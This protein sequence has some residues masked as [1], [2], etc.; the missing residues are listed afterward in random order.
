MKKLPENIVILHNIRSVSN[1]GAMFR[2]ADAVGVNKIYLTGY[3]PG[4]LDRFGRKRKD[5]AK[6]ALGA[7]E[8]V[9]WEQKK[10]LPA[11]ISRLKKEGYLVVAI[12]QDSRSV[13]YRKLKLKN[14]NAFI[15]GPEVTGIPK[16]ILNK[17]DIIA[18]I[19]MHGKKE[20]LNVSVA[21]G[22]ILFRML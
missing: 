10:N 19:P 1:V 2:T 15:V 14:K 4:P 22:V 3:T 12:E 16:N 18:E 13:D 8:F 7:E 5:L 20:S 11:L 9:A 17:C 6:S 21:L